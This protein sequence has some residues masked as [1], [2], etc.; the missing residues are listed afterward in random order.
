VRVAGLR[1]HMSFPRVERSL[2]IFVAVAALAALGAGGCSSVGAD[3]R[4]QIA[5]GGQ[6]R[7]VASPVLGS[8]AGGKYYIGDHDDDDFKH[9]EFDSDDPQ[10]RDY[11]HA[12]RPGDRRAISIVALRYLGAAGAGDSVLA[13]SLLARRAAQPDL[14]IEVPE[15]YE[16]PASRSNLHGKSCPEV[17]S[18]IFAENR[19]ELATELPTVRVTAVRVRGDRGLAL[20]GF[21]AI[22]ERWI[23]V[24]REGESWKV[25]ALLDSEVP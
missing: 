21:A 12:A 17:A 20:L 8:A 7:P 18:P 15:E 16:P 4:T 1:G 10:L 13:C 6:G 24:A 19:A 3:R 11:G 14:R 2:A 9:S 23:A 25:D 5:S 22:P